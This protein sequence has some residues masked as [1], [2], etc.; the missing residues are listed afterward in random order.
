MLRL[1]DDLRDE[2]TRDLAM[3]LAAAVCA[4]FACLFM[5][6]AFAFPMTIG[7]LFLIL[8]MAGALCDGSS[9]RCRPCAASSTMTPRTLDVAAVVVTYNSE[10]HIAALLDSIPAAMGDLA[11]SVVVVDNGSIDATLEI[12]EARGDCIVV[13]SAN[14]GYAARHQSGGARVAAGAARS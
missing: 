13:R 3:A 14:V 6:D 10:D 4:G 2:G 5:F 9:G 7:T 1:R 11:Y 8:G 12:L